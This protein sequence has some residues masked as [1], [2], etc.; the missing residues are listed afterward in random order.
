MEARGF[1]HVSFTCRSLAWSAV[2]IMLFRFSTAE[3]AVETGFFSFELF[4]I[5]LVDS[6]FFVLGFYDCWGGSTKQEMSRMNCRL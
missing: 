5:D 1:I 2:H 4:A 3:A 6:S